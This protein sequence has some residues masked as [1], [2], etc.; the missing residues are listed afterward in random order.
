MFK[1]RQKLGKYRIEGRLA[2]TGYADVYKAFDTIEG[3][4]VALKIP[5][6][7]FRTEPFLQDFRE[8]VRLAGRLEH[9][10]ILPLKNADF[11]GDLFVIVTPL[12]QETFADRIKRRTALP[13]ALDFA[14][15][16]LSAV[17]HAHERRIIHCDIKPENFILFAPNRLRLADFGIAKL[18]FRTV[19]ASGSGTLGYVAPEQAMGRPSYPS[20]VFSLGLIFY[21]MLAGSLPEWPFEWPPAGMERLRRRVSKPMV[22]FLRKSLEREPAQRFR[23]AQQMQAAFSRLKP[24]APRQ[25]RAGTQGRRR[26]KR[27]AAADWQEVRMRQFKRQHGWELETRFAC[28]TCGGPVSEPMMACPWCGAARA[29]FRDETRFPARCP[30]CRRG[31][32]LDWRFCAWCYGPRRRQVAGRRYP[33]R[34]YA[35]ACANPDCRGLLLPFTRYCPWCRRKVQRR[36]RIGESRESCPRCR[37]PVLTNYWSHCPWCRRAL[38]R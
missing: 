24:H 25:A 32:K 7:A 9:P 11:I 16:M 14:G 6:D 10:H 13:L 26:G 15:Q 4:R 28:G 29:V 17:A 31:Q 22:E 2:R 1:Y 38:G 23:D 34:R 20:D 21:R 33:D 18:A 36:W 8:E 35:A 3:C 30:R 12:G 19:K 5:L 37:G 27:P